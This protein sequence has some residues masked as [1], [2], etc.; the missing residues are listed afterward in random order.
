MT[1]VPGLSPDVLAQLGRLGA[2]VPTGFLPHSASAG[3]PA[4]PHAVPLAVRAFLAA[5]RPARQVL[6]VKDGGVDVEIHVPSAGEVGRGRLKPVRP[7]YRIGFDESGFDLLV[8]LGEAAADDDPPT[9]RVERG[10]VRRAPKPKP[11]SVRLAKI[12]ERRPP[13]AKDALAHA[14]AYGDLA[15]VREF[16]AAGASLAPVDKSG[17]TPLHLAALTSGSPELVRSL[18]DAGANVHA[19]VT[20]DPGTMRGIVGVERLRGRGL[21]PGYTPL[22]AAVWAAHPWFLAVWPRGGELAAILLAAGADPGAV[23]DLGRTPLDI[24]ADTVGE[25]AAGI[26]A[27]LRAA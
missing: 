17:V 2:R 20:G 11:L 1:D 4:G 6:L 21:R 3:T 27:L 19:V 10:G 14:C 22:H 12:R 24:A 18:V 13:A 7:W 26:A 8:D 25:T 15:T 5:E 23:D 16:L 9:Y